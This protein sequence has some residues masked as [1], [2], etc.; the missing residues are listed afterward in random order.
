MLQN[1]PVKDNATCATYMALRTSVRPYCYC[2][3]AGQLGH[4]FSRTSHCDRRGRHADEQS[5]LKA[6]AIGTTPK[7]ALRHEAMHVYSLRGLTASSKGH[8]DQRHNAP[9][10]VDSRSY[11]RPKHV[12]KGLD[13]KDPKTCTH[14][15]ASTLRDGYGAQLKRRL[16]KCGLM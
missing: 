15:V 6:V 3:Y 4:C 14:L 2:L 5:D 7:A 10:L 12:K 1:H 16:G 13:F 9:C 11:Q 8:H